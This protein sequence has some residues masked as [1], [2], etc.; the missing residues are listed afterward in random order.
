MDQ[1][2]IFD[3]H[4]DDGNIPEEFMRML[5]DPDFRE[6]FGEFLARR[7]EYEQCRP[8]PTSHNP[9][10]WL[11]WGIIEAI[12]KRATEGL[13]PRPCLSSVILKCHEQPRDCMLATMQGWHHGIEVVA[14]AIA[15]GVDLDEMD[16]KVDILGIGD[17]PASVIAQMDPDERERVLANLRDGTQRG[18][19]GSVE[20]SPKPEFAHKYVSHKPPV[21]CFVRPGEYSSPEQPA[22]KGTTP[23]PMPADMAG[24]LPHAIARRMGRHLPPNELN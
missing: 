9:G 21:D 23:E 8:Q 1:E 24:A 18:A 15:E 14:R 7:D 19:A 6:Q 10:D 5:K 16:F 12:E 3:R 13:R 11:R 22:S 17:M 2:N 4:D 20:M